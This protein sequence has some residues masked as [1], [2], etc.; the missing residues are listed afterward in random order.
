MQAV[1]VAFGILMATLATPLATAAMFGGG[2]YF[3]AEGFA[4]L[5]WAAVQER[6]VVYAML[7]APVALFITT[8]FGA[9]FVH[10]LAELGRATA[11]RTTLAGAIVGALPFLLFDGYVIGMNML[12]LA[13]EPYTEESLINVARWAGMG[14]WCGSWSALVYWLVAIRSRRRV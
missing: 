5:P 14:A 10:R 1:R 4:G 6:I 11:L 7:S 2:W 8:A 9:P 12:L 3:E 13:S